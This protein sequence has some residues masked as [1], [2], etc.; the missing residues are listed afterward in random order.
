[1]KN[2]ILSVAMAASFNAYCSTE[3]WEVIT[4]SI[5]AVD[6]MNRSD[7][8]LLAIYN[9]EKNSS[10]LGFMFKKH[11]DCQH[12]PNYTAVRTLTVDFQ[13]I[14]FDETCDKNGHKSFFPKTRAG[15][16]FIMD[17]LESQHVITLMISGK[18][19]YYS[20]MGFVKSKLKLQD[21]VL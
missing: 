18:P 4:P 8:S 12:T 16:N 5:I 11:N 13:K 3:E 6:S 19:V 21:G 1:M 7:S 14:E 10:D 15:R 17:K 20:A 9:F 2:L